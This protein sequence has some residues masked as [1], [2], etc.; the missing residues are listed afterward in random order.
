MIEGEGFPRK[1]P[2]CGADLTQQDAVEQ[3]SAESGW[4][5]ASIAENGEMVF[6]EFTTND[7]VEVYV[8][9]RCSKCE[10]LLS[11]EEAQRHEAGRL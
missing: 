10:T 11:R 2:E 8:E 6:R 3:E 5:S 7:T 4:W 1:C 9:A